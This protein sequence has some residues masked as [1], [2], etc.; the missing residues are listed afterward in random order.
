[1]L[2]GISKEA[3]AMALSFLTKRG[4]ARVQ[5]AGRVKT[6]LLTSAGVQAHADYL[7]LLKAI[8]KCWV[9]RYGAKTMQDL[10][11]VLERIAGDGTAQGSP[12]FQGLEPYPEGWRAKVRKPVTLPHYPMVLHRGGYPDGS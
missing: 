8:E 12:L 2:G 1:M 4:Y 3:V 7:R 5:T 9:T 11:G 6:L 10:S